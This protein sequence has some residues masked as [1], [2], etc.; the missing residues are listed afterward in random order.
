[1][2]ARPGRLVLDAIHDESVRCVV[3]DLGS[4]PTRDEQSLV[5]TVVLGDLWRH[6]AERR[7]VLIVIDEAH[8]VCPAEPLDPLAALASERAIRI[9]AEGRKFGGALVLTSA[10]RSRGTSFR[11][12]P[13]AAAG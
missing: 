10:C 4:L 1:M 11:P 9:A 3:I 7:P 12:T 5:A 13:G 8:N 2:G 6:R